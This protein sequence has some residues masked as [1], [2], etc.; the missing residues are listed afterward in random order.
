M[1]IQKIYLKFEK[2]RLIFTVQWAFNFI[3][4]KLKKAEM[5]TLHVLLLIIVSP[6]CSKSVKTFLNCIIINRVMDDFDTFVDFSDIYGKEVQMV[7]RLFLVNCYLLHVPRL[8][9]QPTS[10]V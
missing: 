6:D 10:N 3:V 8:P 5:T 1:R 2:T 7:Y 9:S 4:A